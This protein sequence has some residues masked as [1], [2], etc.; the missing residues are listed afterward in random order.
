[1]RRVP[2]HA[3]DT[4]VFL[5]CP[6]R[7]HTKHPSETSDC[8][9]EQ[10]IPLPVQNIGVPATNRKFYETA[11]PFFQFPAE[12]GNPQAGPDYC[13]NSEIFFSFFCQRE[14]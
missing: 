9:P 3:P 11:D 6:E 10:E 12:H 8:P 5:S 7:N 4:E 2:G 14:A 13:Y 1:V